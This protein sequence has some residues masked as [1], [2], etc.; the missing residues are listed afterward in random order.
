MEVWILRILAIPTIILFWKITA[1]IMTGPNEEFT[2]KKSLARKGEK[3]ENVHNSKS[4][5]NS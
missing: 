3:K 2:K 1:R 4:N 5:K